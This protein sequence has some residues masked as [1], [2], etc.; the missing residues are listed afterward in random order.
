[1]S[2]EEIIEYDDSIGGLDAPIGDDEPVPD[3]HWE[4]INERMALYEKEGFQGRPWEEVERE[5]REK[6]TKH[7]S[8]D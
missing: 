6:L 3:W 8:K 2:S 4:I 5:L 1:M 7:L